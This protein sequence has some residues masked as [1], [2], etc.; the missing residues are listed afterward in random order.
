MDSQGS[1]L[2]TDVNTSEVRTFSK[3][4]SPVSFRITEFQ[5]HRCNP[6]SFQNGDKFVVSE[7]SSESCKVECTVF[8]SAVSHA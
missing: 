1:H 7:D 3:F 2:L 5:L 8:L 6:L 4:L